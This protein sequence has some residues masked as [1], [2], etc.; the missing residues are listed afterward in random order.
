MSTIQVWAPA[1]AVALATAPSLAPSLPIPSALGF[2]ELRPYDVESSVLSSNLKKTLADFQRVMDD[3]PKSASGYCIDEIELN[4]GFTSKGGIAFFTKLE[5]GLDA[6]IKVK[7]K[8]E[9]AK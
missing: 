4:M 8:R 1:P 6:A 7:I 9:S 2:S 3:L 5:V